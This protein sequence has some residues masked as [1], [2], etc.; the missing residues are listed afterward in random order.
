MPEETFTV[1]P[2][3]VVFANKTL[4]L[5][6]WKARDH[7]PDDH[8][9]VALP[10]EYDPKAKCETYE[11]VLDEALGESA[12][13]F[14]EFAGLCLT[15]DTSYEI[16]VWL[17]GPRGAGKST[18]IEG[19]HAAMGDLHGALSLSDISESRF[20]LGAVPGKTLLTAT[21]QSEKYIKEYTGVINAII[22]GE[23]ITVDRKF[24]NPIIIKSTAKILWAMN[25][26]PRVGTATDGIFRRV[27]VIGFRPLKGEV[28]TTLKAKIA[29]E[30]AGIFNWALRGLIRLRGRGCFDVPDEVKAATDAFLIDND[31]VREFID[32]RCSISMMDQ[33]SFADLHEAYVDW[34]QGAGYKSAGRRNFNADIRRVSDELGLDITEDRKTKGLYWCGIAPTGARY[35]RA[36]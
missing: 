1:K 2:S 4:D 19:L 10:F 17:Y 20:G 28:D 3:V 5:E 35:G 22:S 7:K 30:R 23:E 8:A 33:C 32:E 16:S 14:Q 21:D 25:N 34:C 36:E 6:A 29:A 12:G 18:L 13:F 24:K 31:H 11:R 26:L 27:K 15:P 9:T